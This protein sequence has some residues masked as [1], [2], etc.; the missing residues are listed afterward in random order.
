MARA[1]K[2]SAEELSLEQVQKDIALLKRQQRAMQAR[3]DLLAYIEFTS[4]DPEDPNDIT[5]S[6]YKAAKH[7]KAV[8]HAVQ[9]FVEGGFPGYNILILEMPP[10]HGKTEIVSKKLPA[11][12]SGK[13]PRQNIVCAAYGDELAMDNGADVRRNI[14]SPQHKQVFPGHRLLR[15][16]TAKDRMQTDAGGLLAFVGRG[17]TLTGRGAHLLICDDLVK[18]DQEAASETLRDQMWN[19]YTKV[20]MTRRMGRKLVILTFTRWHQDDIIGR[21]TDENNEQ[22]YNPDLAK[23]IKIISLPAFAEENDDLGRE[24]GEAL[25]PD[26][27][28]ADYLRE[29]QQVLGP[30]GFAALYQQ[31]PTVDDGILFRR[32]NLRFYDPEELP[33]ELRF[34]AASDHAVGEKQQHDPTCMGKA[35]VD[36][37]DNI[38]LLPDLFWRRAPADLVVESMLAMVRGEQ[39]PLIWWAEKGHISKSIGPFIRKRMAE[40]STYFN[41]VEVTPSGDKVQRAQSIAAR[42]ANY[43]VFLPRNAPWTQ[44]AV[45]ELLAFPNGL[46]DD[47]VDMIAYLGLGLHVQIRAAG[48][49]QDKREPRFGTMGWIRAQQRR[50]EREARALAN[51]GF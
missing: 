34:Y 35:G 33:A 45:E 40:T 24:P 30:V 51:G 27:Y 19:W 1:P 43:K 2:K 11:W 6:S 12:Y 7:H 50:D 32:E 18:N 16:G 21:L 9:T 41:L 31:K 44:R 13:Y 3:D 49:S 47:F 29:Q 39:R 36:R 46:H 38:Y 8:A 15:G 20:A 14:T 26:F 48:P 22:H 28:D 5:R 37:Y 23:K 42:F 10:R 17:S 25:W 4:P